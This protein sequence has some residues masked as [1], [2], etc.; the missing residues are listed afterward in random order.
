MKIIKEE[1]DFIK[2]NGD[3]PRLT[4]EGFKVVDV[5]SDVLQM[6]LN[7]YDRSKMIEEKYEGKDHY[8]KEKCYVQDIN[9]NQEIVKYIKK[10]LLPMHESWSGVS[11]TPAVLYGIRSYS[12]NSVFKA[13]VDQPKTHHVA[14][15]ITLGKDSEWGLNVQNHEGE[16]YDVDVPV[17]KMIMFE[18]GTIYHGRLEPFKGTYYDNIYMHYSINGI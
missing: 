5:P 2:Y 16:W 17:G 10:A 4:K 7:F 15:S 12:N 8:I 14:S 11:L 18:S 6:L 13:H 1:R 9:R 3:L